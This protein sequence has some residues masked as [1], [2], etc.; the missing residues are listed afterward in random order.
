MATKIDLNCCYVDMN[1]RI[2]HLYLKFILL[3]LLSIYSM[4]IYETIIH[5]LLKDETIGKITNVSFGIF[6]VFHKNT[7]QGIEVCFPPNAL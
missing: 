5:N 4:N 7:V 6:F 3:V 2:V 1:L